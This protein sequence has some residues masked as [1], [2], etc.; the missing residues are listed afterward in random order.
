MQG[1]LQVEGQLRMARLEQVET[2]SPKGA[3]ASAANAAAA[4]KRLV[5]VRPGVSMFTNYRAGTGR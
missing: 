5:H 3:A 4:K 1:L 2:Q